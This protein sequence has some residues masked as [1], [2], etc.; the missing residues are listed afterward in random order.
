MALCD[1]CAHLYCPERW[2]GGKCSSF[3]PLAP[4]PRPQTQFTKSPARCPKSKSGTPKLTR[5]PLPL[6][7]LFL[8]GLVFLSLVPIV[9]LLAAAP[10]SLLELAKFVLAATPLALLVHELGHMAVARS[11]GVKVEKLVF[12]PFGIGLRFKGNPPNE[13]YLKICSGG[14]LANLCLA[15]VL[16][17][18]SSNPFALA[19]AL[20]SFYLFLVNG[21]PGLRTDGGKIALTLVE[22]SEAYA[23][24]YA[25]SLPASALL[26]AALFAALL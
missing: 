18:L 20:V 9:V 2:I 26:A 12:A 16:T 23:Y 11:L 13:A 25:L 1:R 22:R 7:L 21:L 24:A 5:A 8:P 15:L 3:I 10:C 6:A 4:T 19:L 14:P 17:P